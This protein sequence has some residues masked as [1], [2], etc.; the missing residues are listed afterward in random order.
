MNIPTPMPMPHPI[1]RSPI[2]IE[3]GEYYLV[4]DKKLDDT[5]LIKIISITPEK[6]FY[7][8]CEGK[9]MWKKVISTEYNNWTE[10]YIIEHL[11][12][13]YVQHL[14]REQKLERIVNE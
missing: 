5:K 9:K 11:T 1:Q 2:K 14:F 7:I 4:F 3:I 12:K 6:H 8:E 13:E 10:Y